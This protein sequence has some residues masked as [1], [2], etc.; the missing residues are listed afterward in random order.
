LHFVSITLWKQRCRNSSPVWFASAADWSESPLFV[1]RA[2]VALAADPAILE[3]SGQLFSSWD[4]GREYR[5]TDA[6]G[7][8]P[9]WG[10]SKI[11]FSKHPEQLL[12]ATTDEDR[13]WP[14]YADGVG[15]ESL[16]NLD[17]RPISKDMDLCS[18]AFRGLDQAQ[19][20]FERAAAGVADDTRASPDGA[21]I[22]T[23]DLSTAMVGL[24]SAR[25]GVEA[26]V[27]LLK[28]ANDMQRQIIDLLA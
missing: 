27:K 18:I 13:G 1:G 11:D 3:R 5:F 25:N 23:V 15:E 17:C 9:D 12:Q 21:A 20:R 28:I 16:K 24:L 6:G 19:T 4:L 14:P 26:N 2:V 22:D 7:R 10:V 8:R